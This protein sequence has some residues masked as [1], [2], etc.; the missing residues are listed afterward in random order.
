M[1]D[2][3]KIKRKVS[4]HVNIRLPLSQTTRRF[5]IGIAVVTKLQP[6]TST[7]SKGLTKER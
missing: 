4:V 5:H 6:R 7:P 1:T 2:V 3:R